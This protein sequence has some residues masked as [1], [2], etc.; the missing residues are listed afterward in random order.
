MSKTIKIIELLNKIANGEEVPK[1]IE[2][3]ENI[4]EYVSNEKE[5]IWW[6]DEERFIGQ[7]LLFAVM[8]EHRINEI[9]NCEVEIIEDK[10]E[11][12]I[13][14]IERLEE[15]EEYEVDKTDVK[16]NRQIINKLVQAVKQL[17]NKIKEVSE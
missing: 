5:Y 4:F 8:E 3:E 1:K 16:V 12:D 14:N 15:V 17:D 11:I 2:F 13:Q 10:Q 7:T 6:Q 9:L